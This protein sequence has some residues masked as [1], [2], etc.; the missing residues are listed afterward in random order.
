[1]A[2]WALELFE[3]DL[4]FCPRPSIKAQVLV[5]FMTECT[6]PHE[7]PEGEEAPTQKDPKMQWN[8]YVNGASNANGSGVGLILIS[9]EGWDIQY[10]LHFGF[11]STNNEAKY[12]ALII[13]LAIIRKWECNT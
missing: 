7:Q 8:L 9:P 6:I 13:E 4:I 2:K 10:A 5:D 12:E 11:P 3:F 1:M